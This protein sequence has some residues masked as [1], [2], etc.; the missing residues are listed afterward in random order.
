LSA[1]SPDFWI[2]ISGPG[3]GGAEESTDMS[4][5]SSVNDQISRKAFRA[6]RFFSTIWT[7]PEGAGKRSDS[8][9]V[10]RASFASSVC[11]HSP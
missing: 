2:S 10:R 5:G 4:F 7:G 8:E 11:S 3:E 6:S 1:E 9:N